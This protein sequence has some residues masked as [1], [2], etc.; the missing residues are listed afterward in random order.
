MLSRTCLIVALA[1]T[2]STAEAADS[3]NVAG[4]AGT[5]SADFLGTT[6]AK[7]LS[8]RADSK[9]AITI[10]PSGDVGI[11][12]ATPTTTLDVLGTLKTSEFLLP[13][14]AKDGYVLT[15]DANGRA[16]WK[17]GTPGPKGDTGATGPAGPIGLT[18][19][20]GPVGATGATGPRGA[21]GPT[22]ATGAQGLPGFVTLPYAG[23]G[24]AASGALFNLI[25]TAAGDAV[26]IF[27]NSS[28]QSGN[29][30]TF[31]AENTGGSSATFGNY[32]SAGRFQTL[33]PMNESTAL[34]VSTNGAG[35]AVDIISNN[36]SPVSGQSTLDVVNEGGGTSIGGEYG[37]AGNFSIANKMNYSSVLTASTNGGGDAII[38]FASGGAALVGN[39]NGTTGGVGVL[40]TSS[41]GQSAHF[42]GGSSGNG[43]CAYAGGTGWNCTSDR[44]LKEHF[45]EIDPTA[46]LAQVASLP[47]WKYQMKHGKPAEWFM[48]PTAQDFRAAFGLGS[49]DTTINTGNA[50]GVALSAI[51]GLNQKLEAEIKAKDA[52]IAALKQRVTTEEKAMAS[53]KTA[54]DASLSA[55]NA[56]LSAIEQKLA[57]KDRVAMR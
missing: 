4:N 23:T 5:T 8:L 48:G 14:G 31:L 52:E 37:S 20:T 16:A 25:N 51:K 40:G 30:N 2:S 24:A 3:W 46:V 35:D 26:D 13:T 47:E 27:S 21:T 32:G 39:D 7:P 17:I 6:D 55:T 33:N 34:I 57:A 41:Q 9:A 38:A 36:A 11:G 1:A 29:L 19:A 45:T 44:N 53:L 15:T 18:G 50:Q 22:G 54:T 43:Y 42:F 28:T 49:N 12:I 10:L 56:R